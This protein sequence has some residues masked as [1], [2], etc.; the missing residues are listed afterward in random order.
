M[1]GLLALL[2]LGAAP[3][4]AIQTATEIDG[5]DLVVVNVGAKGRCSARLVVR[6]GADADPSG[7]AGLAHLVEHLTMSGDQGAALLGSAESE[8]NAITWS[9]GTVFSLDSTAEGCEADLTRLLS[10]ATDG[11]LRKLWFDNE[12]RVVER[13][14]VYS[15]HTTSGLVEAGLFGDRMISVLGSH[16]TR[17]NITLAD[18]VRFYRAQ[19]VPANIALIVIGPLDLERVR[20]TLRAGFKLAPTLPSERE[21]RK[22]LLV[23]F[24]GD[25]EIANAYGGISVMSVAL[26][27]REVALCLNLAALLELRVRRLLKLS[28]VTEISG[29]CLVTGGQLLAATLAI[30][31]ES[32]RDRVRQLLLEAWDAAALPTPA[33]RKALARRFSRSPDWLGASPVTAADALAHAAMWSRGDDLFSQVKTWVSPQVLDPKDFKRLPELLAKERRIFMSGRPSE[34]P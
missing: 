32:D 30:G 11:E 1:S 25:R 6:A 5:M 31:P 10:V 17:E 29:D 7:K 19:Y 12:Q 8:I 27:P 20:R 28:G 13:E 24:Q 15:R 4:V 18:V 26:P 21:E 3:Q 16:A 34:E 33:E 14:Q 2:A 9:D 23:K 22:P